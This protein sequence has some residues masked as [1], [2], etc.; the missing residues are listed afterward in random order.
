MGGEKLRKV[1]KRCHGLTNHRW[2]GHLAAPVIV[3]M[4]STLTLLTIEVIL[5]WLYYVF[6]LSPSAAWALSTLSHLNSSAYCQ[7]T[8]PNPPTPP[9]LRVKS[10]L[11]GGSG[12]LTKLGPTRNRGGGLVK[13]EER[14]GFGDEEPRGL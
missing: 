10:P 13:E 4:S 6:K 5:F 12:G 3:S 2:A 7:W 1:E 9:Y 11:L 8:S 14:E